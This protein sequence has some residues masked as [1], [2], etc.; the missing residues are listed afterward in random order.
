[1]GLFGGKSP[2][3]EAKGDALLASDPLAAMKLF[4]EAFRKSGY[5]NPDDAAR[6][7]GKIREARQAFLRAKLREAAQFAE[8]GVYDAAMESLAIARENATPDDEELAREIA[9]ETERMAQLE[10]EAR[11]A[12]RSREE[13][14]DPG[15]VPGAIDEAEPLPEEAPLEEM[16]AESEGDEFS[17][18][19]GVLSP[20]DYD[21]ALELGENFQAGF[22]AYQRGDRQTARA[23]FEQEAARHPLDGLVHEMLAFLLDQT[24]EEVRAAEHFRE[25]VRID[26]RR[27]NARLALAQILAGIGRRREEGSATDPQSALDLLYGGVK[28]DP[29]DTDYSLAVAEVLI[30][31][32]RATE[33]K[34]ILEPLLDGELAADPGAWQYY[35]LALEVEGS[36]DEAEAAHDHLVRLSG[37]SMAPRGL[38]AEFALRHNRWL[39]KAERLIFETCIG[40]QASAPSEESLDR[41][42]VLLSRIQFA[43]GE[44]KAA[45]DGVERLLAKGAPQD[46]APLLQAMRAEAKKR[47]AASGA[48][49]GA[50]AEEDR[51]A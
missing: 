37:Q 3:H 46:L 14:V 51:E 25:A 48:E 35:A 26:P 6:L 9:G 30:S 17:F 34:E 5:K 16:Q 19:A 40:C 8:D 7:K 47:M 33:A 42:G 13:R 20:E 27:K 23:A 38:Y 29:D 1:M 43:R 22:I 36:L 18:Y 32:K 50:G 45:L 24:G 21:H 11:P 15:F 12:A 10:V 39:D 44:Y 2:S 41:Y 28:L 49:P 4:R 31:E